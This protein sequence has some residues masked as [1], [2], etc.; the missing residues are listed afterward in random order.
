MNWFEDNKHR[1]IL[2]IGS[3]KIKAGLSNSQL[4][5]YNID[6]LAGW[7]IFNL[8]KRIFYFII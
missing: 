6:N 4:P 2:D 7:T 5:L 3:H 1:V 8:F